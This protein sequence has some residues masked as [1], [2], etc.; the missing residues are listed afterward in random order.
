MDARFGQTWEEFFLFIR[1]HISYFGTNF[2]ALSNFEIKSRSDLSLGVTVDILLF[3]LSLESFVVLGDDN[4]ITPESVPPPRPFPP[5]LHN[6]NLD[7]YDGTSEFF[8][9]LLSLQDGGALSANIKCYQCGGLHYKLECPQLKGKALF[10]VCNIVNNVSEPEGDL[11]AEP[12]HEGKSPEELRQAHEADKEPGDYHGN[13]YSLEGEYVLEEYKEYSDNRGDEH[14]AHTEAEDGETLPPLMFCWDNI[15]ETDSEVDSNKDDEQSVY[16]SEHAKHGCFN[17][18]DNWSEDSEVDP[19]KD[20]EGS[21]HEPKP[22]LRSCFVICDNWS[23]DKWIVNKDIDQLAKE[24]AN[25]FRVQPKWLL[26]DLVHWPTNQ[27]AAPTNTIVHLC[28]KCKKSENFCLMGYMCI[29]GKAAFA[30][31]DNRGM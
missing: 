4:C 7:V 18:C 6:L 15:S 30:W 25:L 11:P 26:N 31:F 17:I 8:A 14:F 1:P 27:Q 28:P 21:L 24:M 20:D 9:Y 23:E 2:S 16:E 22:A 19:K 3:L 10:A 13:Q 29:N 12:E 5:R